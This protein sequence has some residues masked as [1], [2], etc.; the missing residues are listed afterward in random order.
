VL[1]VESRDLAN[2]LTA[3]ARTWSVGAAAAAPIFN[4]EPTRA[5]V[6]LSESI[7]RE[8]V[9]VGRNSNRVRCS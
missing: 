6:R 9:V 5:N 7:E 8:L 1:G 3:P 4:A 2:L